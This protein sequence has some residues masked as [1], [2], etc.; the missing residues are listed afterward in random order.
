MARVIVS[1]LTQSDTIRLISDLASKAGYGVAA[2]Y[3][4]DFD[5]LYTRLAAHP[6]SGPLRPLIG[7]G[8]RIG[9]VSPF[10]ALYEHHQ[11]TDTVTVFRVVHGRRKITEAILRGP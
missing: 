1:L 8:V 7:R 2:R 9:I 6:E 11:R 3:A 4:A 10:L 5:N